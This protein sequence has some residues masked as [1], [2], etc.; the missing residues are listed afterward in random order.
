MCDVTVSMVDLGDEAG[1]ATIFIA[2]IS[3]VGGDFLEDLG[4][5]AIWA[6]LQVRWREQRGILQIH[7]LGV[8][9][10]SRTNELIGR[11]GF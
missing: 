1:W 11:Q 8:S 4:V 3:G 9:L 5:L 10:S 7:P 2:R 6:M